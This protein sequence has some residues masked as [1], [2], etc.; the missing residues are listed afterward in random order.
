MSYIFDELV[1]DI[2][3]NT[4]QTLTEYTLKHHFNLTNFIDLNLK[5]EYLIRDIEITLNF[6]N[7]SNLSLVVD[8]ITSNEDAYFIIKPSM[9]TGILYNDI[10]LYTLPFYYKVFRNKVELISFINIDNEFNENVTSITLFEPFGYSIGNNKITIKIPVTGY[11]ILTNKH[12]IDIKQHVL[13][14]NSHLYKLIAYSSFDNLE[15][16]HTILEFKLITEYKFRYVTNYYLRNMLTSQQIF[17]PYSQLSITPLNASVH[18][19]KKY[20]PARYKYTDYI[21]KYVYGL[22]DYLADTNNVTNYESLHVVDLLVFS[23]LPII[24]TEQMFLQLLCRPKIIKRIKV[25]N[26]DITFNFNSSAI[27]GIR[28]DD[29]N[30]SLNINF[31]DSNSIPVR[32]FDM[33]SL[34]L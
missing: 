8:F 28:E 21:N 34:I 30:T 7:L 6:N 29:T 11:V 32:L 5:K 3:L 4:K 31:I 17:T 24:Y 9:F 10:T 18:M 23:F 12:F 14:S 25:Y 27:V 13:S 19:Q 20:I 1:K 2:D 33:Y 15:I 26:T 16:L 22:I